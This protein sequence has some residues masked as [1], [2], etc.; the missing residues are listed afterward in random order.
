MYTWKLLLDIKNVATWNFLKML[1]SWY[2]EKL[3]SE[4]ILAG[5]S[6]DQSTTEPVQGSVVAKTG[7]CRCCSV[8]S[9][10]RTEHQKETKNSTK[11][12]IIARYWVVMYRSDW[13][14]LNVTNWMFVQ[15]PSRFFI[16]W[17]SASRFSLGYISDGHVK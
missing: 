13:L 3:N 11:A 9:F 2:F 10:I 6:M 14:I 12:V 17:A 15:S 7:W 16:A 8:V 5:Q 4:S 1:M